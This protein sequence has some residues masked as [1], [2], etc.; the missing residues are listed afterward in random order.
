MTLKQEFIDMLE[1]VT[2]DNDYFENDDCYIETDSYRSICELTGEDETY[3]ICQD[4]DSY[5]KDCQ[6]KKQ[7]KVDI[8]FGIYSEKEHNYT[9]CKEQSEVKGLTYI[10]NRKKLL[11]EIKSIKNKIEESRE[12]YA[13]FGL[14]Y[15]E[16]IEYATQFAEQL[17]K[18]YSFFGCIDTNI[19]PIVLHLNFAHTKNHQIDW[20]LGGSF[21]CNGEQ[22]IIVIYNCM[23]DIE[24]IKRNVRHEL[25]HY[26]LYVCGLKYLDDD[27][28][29]HYLCNQYDALAYKTMGE[30]EQ[31]L[32]D[33]LISAINELQN[34]NIKTE[35]SDYDIT[36]NCMAMVF[37]VGCVPD[38][39]PNGLEELANEG[40]KLLKFVEKTA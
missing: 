30:E 1:V 9:F 25:I 32:Y 15:N 13:A 33:E 2:G 22:N 26:F 19:L 35:L 39:I 31:K 7:I 29:F 5:I 10:G 3:S 21:V 6:H 34:E 23:D 16:V 11:E 17:K 12:Y 18:D 27:A 36:A 37:A 28:I 24:A 4:C 40:N 14:R 38:N 8:T 20:R